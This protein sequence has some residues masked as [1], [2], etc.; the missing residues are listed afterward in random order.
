MTRSI[1]LHRLPPAQIDS[2]GMVACDQG[3]QKDLVDMVL[4]C[5]ILK[6]N[7]TLS[8]DPK[9]DSLFS[10]R[11]IPLLQLVHAWIV[12]V[13]QCSMRCTQATMVSP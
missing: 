9:G 6:R 1:I 5:P 10:F 7:G 8:P 4:S 3:P 11:V 13:E 12:R 2:V